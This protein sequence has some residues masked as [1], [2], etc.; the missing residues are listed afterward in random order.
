M[1]FTF[2][3]DELALRDAVNRFL[4]TEAAPEVLREI[5]QEDS[6]RS[7]QLR[8][9][10]V[11]QGL[12]A[13]SIDEQYGGLAMGDLVWSLMSQELG[14]YAIPDSLIGTA[15][16]GVG[17]ISGLADDVPQKSQWLEQICTGQLRVAVSHPSN[18]LVGD[19]HLCDLILHFDNDGLYALSPEDVEL[20][21]NGSIDTSRRLYAMA[22]KNSQATLIADSSAAQRLMRRAQTQGTLANAG[23]M[24]GLAQRMLDLSIDYVTQRKQFGKPIG[25]FQAIKHKL[26]D[27]AS[28]IEIAK[29]ALYRAAY[30]MQNDHPLAQLHASETVL[31]CRSA[32]ALAAKHGIQVHGAMGYTWEVDLQ[33]FMKRCYALQSHWGVD[34]YHQQVLFDHIT[35][36]GAEIGPTATFVQE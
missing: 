16:I 6:G 13:L 30:S 8:Q 33:M 26:A 23:Q 31:L 36:D 17:I 4:M 18:P 2:S 12:T 9:A 20:T 25:S 27:V 32:G 29:P 24:I 3:E 11:E 14:Y 34:G 15:Y 22:I 28:K 21:L 5:W 1:D 7:P 35:A 19:A 10:M